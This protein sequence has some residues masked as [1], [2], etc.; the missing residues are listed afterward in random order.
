MKFKV[1]WIFF[2][3]VI[4]FSF[5][6]LCLSE[7]LDS[8]KWVF[9]ADNCYYNKNFIQSDKIISIWTYFMVTDDFRKETI[10]EI[11]KDDL[12]KSMHYQ[13]YDYIISL[14]EL[15]CRKRL[16]RMKEFMDCDYDGNILDHVMNNNKNWERI[17]LG[18]SFDKLYKKV[19]LTGKKLSRKKKK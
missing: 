14:N 5:S 7:Q 9:F 13:T 3:A 12:K 18:S 8:Q 17:T 19:C 10:Q 11:K 15:D 1:L 16:F 4:I 6:S 2:L